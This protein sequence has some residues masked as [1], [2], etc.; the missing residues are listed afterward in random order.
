MNYIMSD[1]ERDMYGK[2]ESYIDDLVRNEPNV[3]MVIMSLLSDSQE[4]MELSQN[5]RAR[6]LINQAKYL[7][8]KYL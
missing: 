1:K 3:K 5:E 6:K 4:L 2:P 8:F 7:M